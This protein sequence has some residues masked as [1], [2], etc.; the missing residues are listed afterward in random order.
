MA[1]KSKI[2]KKRWF[3]IAASQHFNNRVFGETIAEDPA[4][5]AGRT[6]TVSMMNLTGEMK[7]QNINITFE[8]T[9]V[10][11]DKA[12]TEIRKYKLTPASIKRYVRKGKNRLDLSFTCDTA[13]GKTVT[14]KPFFLTVRTTGGAH[15]T[16]LR[17]EAAKLIKEAIKNTK[18]HDLFTNII[19][20]RFQREI[21]MKLNKIYPLKSCEIRVLEL[22]KKKGYF[23]P[24]DVKVETPKEEIKVEEEKKIET[25]NEE[26]KKMVVEETISKK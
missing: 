13:D 12:R 17:K 22:K 7:R 15:L 6:V 11:E 1:V 25:P 2:K 24:K 19:T 23:A 3:Q 16:L 8:I 18:Y 21:R 26:P 5:L 4:N 20:N 10:N 9:N 14:I